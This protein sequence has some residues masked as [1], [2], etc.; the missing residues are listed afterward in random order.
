MKK[1]ISED[2]VNKLNDILG[3][4]F[5]MN[6]FCDNIAYALDCELECQLASKVY[7]I[8]FSHD[9]PSDNLADKLSDVM[10]YSNIRPVRKALQENISTYENIV[11]A[12]SDNV[13][14]MEL[15]RELIY[16]SI[17]E[18]DY[19]FNNKQLVLALEDILLHIQ[20]LLKQ[21]YIWEE[22]AIEY[23]KKDDV[24]GFNIHFEEFT[25]LI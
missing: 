1:Y 6:S 17:E 8:K 9:F 18:L 12:F 7:H 15:L 5:Q 20:I 25:T 22:K 23:F 10:I 14:E 13:K 24:R 21:S 2:V 11:I 4:M 3:R 16:K 19:D